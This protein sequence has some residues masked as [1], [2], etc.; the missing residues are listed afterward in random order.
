MSVLTSRN[1]P[2]FVFFYC[3]L[4]VIDTHYAERCY[5]QVASSFQNPSPKLDSKDLSTRFIHS[6]GQSQNI[7]ELS[8]ESSSR[9]EF[10]DYSSVDGSIETVM[11]AMSSV[12][13]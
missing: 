5:L 6:L 11:L 10:E 8:Y 2:A 7:C 12:M 13:A 1:V 3:A 4:A 9:R